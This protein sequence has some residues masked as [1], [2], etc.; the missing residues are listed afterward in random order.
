M[1]YR[2]GQRQQQLLFPPRIEDYI[3]QDDPVRVYD[4]FVNA[5]SWETLQ[6]EGNPKKAGCPQYDP[7]SMLK[8]L[9]YAYSY[10]IRSSRKIERALHHNVSFI[11]LA[12]GLK[13]DYRTISRFRKHNAKALKQTLKQCAQLCLKLNV[14]AGNTLFVDGSK[15]RANAGIDNTRSRS[16]CEKALTELDGRIEQLLGECEQADHM[17]QGQGSFVALQEELTEQQQLKEKVQEVLDTLHTEGLDRMNTTDP[18]CARM[19]GRQGS[20]AGYNGQ[21]VV[22][23]KHGFIVSSDVVNENNDQNQFAH[24]I[25]Q[26]HETLGSPCKQA[27]ADAGYYNGAELEKIDRQDVKVIVPSREQASKK[28]PKPFHKNQFKYS[29][30]QDCYICPE[31][32]RLPKRSYS[33]AEKGSSYSAGAQVCRA[34]CHFGLCTAAKHHG[35]SIL[36]YDNQEVRARLARQY[37]QSDSQST[38]ARRKETVELPF[39]HIKSNLGVSSFLLRGL[40]SVR[41]EMSLLCSCFNIVRLIGLFGVSGLLSKLA[42][43]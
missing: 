3:S 39:G 16:W 28:P 21:I 31:G 2:F 24:Q 43:W 11:W 32:K 42:S 30:E 33:L 9:I 18:D 15:F 26:A 27:G 14:I 13:P 25:E 37:E 41:A 7:K 10:G 19:T 5:L 12:G 29:P 34:C 6:L 40:E 22:D 4:A 23:E 38:F 8:I 35:R 1:A 20:H 17:E 36:R